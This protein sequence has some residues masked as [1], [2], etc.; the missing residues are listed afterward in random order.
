[1]FQEQFAQ[2][3]VG[4]MVATA[5]AIFLAPFGSTTVV[6]VVQEIIFGLFPGDG[7]SE[8]LAHIPLVLVDGLAVLSDLP[9][10]ELYMASTSALVSRVGSF[11]PLRSSLSG[12]VFLKHDIALS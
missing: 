12:M 10:G 6:A 11:V 5:G 7:P 3:A 2:A 1:M 9:F 4:Q 8:P